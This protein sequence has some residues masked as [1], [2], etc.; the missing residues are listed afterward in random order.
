M[1]YFSPIL[2]L[3]STGSSSPA[4]KNNVNQPLDN[5]SRRSEWKSVQISPVKEHSAKTADNTENNHNLEKRVF[6]SPHMKRTF[7]LA[8]EN[9]FYAMAWLIDFS[10]SDDGEPHF[11]YKLQSFNHE[12][13]PPKILADVVVPLI[14]TSYNSANQYRGKANVELLCHLAKE[15][16]HVYFS[17][18]VFASGASFVIGKIIDYPTVYVNNQFRKV[19]KFDIAGAI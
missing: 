2:P 14:T 9:T 12:D 18:E 8:L 3:F 7:T 13:N 16:V 1:L 5:I 6:T 15:Y 4:T 10:F 17:V 19:V 11:S